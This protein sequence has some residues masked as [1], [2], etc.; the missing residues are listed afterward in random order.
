MFLTVYANDSCFIVCQGHGDNCTYSVNGSTSDLIHRE[1]AT[2]GPAAAYVPHGLPESRD[3]SKTWYIEPP[4]P[5][6]PERNDLFQ[7]LDLYE[8]KIPFHP[9][10]L[11]VLD[12]LGV[13]KDEG[14]AWTRRN[15]RACISMPEKLVN[16]FEDNTC[17]MLVALCLGN[18]LL[19]PRAF[20]KRS[21][22]L[23]DAIKALTEFSMWEFF[24]PEIF[25]RTFEDLAQRVVVDRNP[26]GQVEKWRFSRPTQR[27]KAPFLQM[28]S[29]LQPEY[30]RETLYVVRSQLRTQ[31]KTQLV[32]SWIL[33]QSAPWLQRQRWEAKVEVAAIVYVLTRT[34]IHSPSVYDPKGENGNKSI[35]EN[36]D[37]DRSRTD[38]YRILLQNE[39]LCIDE[40]LRQTEQKDRH[41]VSCALM[42]LM[43]IVDPDE[44]L[45]LSIVEDDSEPQTRRRELT[46]VRTTLCYL[47]DES[48]KAAMKS[49]FV[50]AGPGEI[51]GSKIENLD[52][53]KR[54]VNPELTSN[55]D[56]RSDPCRGKTRVDKTGEDDDF[57]N[58]VEVL[59]YRA[60]LYSAMLDLCADSSAFEEGYIDSVVKIT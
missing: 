29:F 3:R 42:V 51:C 15:L 27:R 32:S 18:V 12:S 53:G 43:K 41:V 50:Y 26:P 57:W 34:I 40:W 1:F 6:P 55:S 58:I 31:P 48:Y 38:Q 22:K 13:E 11:N 14:F 10:E 47:P 16:F 59:R 9:T 56:V 21:A 19:R 44:G 28:Q 54:R 33:D 4:Q 24:G 52:R 46:Q 49:A 37:G 30:L 35:I 60:L 36:S 39:V 23:I 5:P 2:I 20:P 45:S 7:S 8:G 25:R 17:P